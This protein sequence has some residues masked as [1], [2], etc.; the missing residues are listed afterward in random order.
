MNATFVGRCRAVLLV[1]ACA[2]GF[3]GQTTGVA[4]ARRHRHERQSS[5]KS[6]AKGVTPCDRL[7]ADP[8]DL[9]KVSP[10]VALKAIKGSEA[11]KQCQPLR[12]KFPTVARFAYQTGRSLESL[13][14]LPEALA[15][16]R[17][18]AGLGSSVSACRAGEMLKDGIG[19]KADQREA[20]RLLRLGV[21]KGDIACSL[22]LARQLAEGRG[23]RA[24]KGEAA[25]LYKAAAAKG[26][27]DALN[28][29]GE[30]LREGDGIGRDEKQAAGLFDKAA[31]R[32][33]VR[34]LFNLGLAY[35]DGTGVPRDMDKALHY[36]EQAGTRGDHEALLKIAYAYLTG[37]GVKEDDRRALVY[38]EKAASA[39]N[40]DGM[41]GVAYI[42]ANAR[43][44][45][46]DPVQAASWLYKALAAG[47][48]YALNQMTD[49][50]NEWSVE[51]RK[52]LEEAL[53]AKGLLRGSAD[54]TFA[55]ETMAAIHKLAGK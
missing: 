23:V 43:G 1:L 2:A 20:T 9:S 38:Y 13:G 44:V 17:D 26:D 18:G 37:N 40:A 45:E 31:G 5:P 39:G 8:S 48:S 55:P 32:G 7:A 16:Y 19:G 29:L 10:G 53:I 4:E 33:S 34:A 41:A 52:A 6:E 25:K 47:S 46:A 28:S 11:L 42:F 15:A 35:R 36:F 49:H 51:V 30:L 21:D 14:K 54:G 50:S 24:S 12:K 22:A 3:V 27:P